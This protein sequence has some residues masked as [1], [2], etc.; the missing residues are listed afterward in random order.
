LGVSKSVVFTGGVSH[1]EII[2]YLD[3]ADVFVMPSRK[4][5]N[6]VEGLPNALIEASARGKPV[7]AGNQGGSLEAV[8]DGITGILV[9][10]ESVTEIAEAV[11]SLLRDPGKAGLMGES[12]REMVR[13]LHT[14][15]AMIEKY[16]DLLIT[17]LDKKSRRS[18]IV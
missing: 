8:R 6:K 11:C 2:D 17:A 9:D 7:I 10:P 15:T 1:E 18:N 16:V 3:L 14:E 12:G 4:W 13:Q 5:D